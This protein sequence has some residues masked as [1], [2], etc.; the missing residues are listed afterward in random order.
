MPEPTSEPTGLPTAY[1]SPACPAGTERISVKFDP[2]GAEWA[3][4]VSSVYSGI[5]NANVP[6]TDDNILLK[7]LP[8][9][10]RRLDEEWTA[11]QICAKSGDYYFL[12]ECDCAG[13]AAWL[14][15]LNRPNYNADGSETYECTYS[16]CSDYGLN[17]FLAMTDDACD[18]SYAGIEGT[19]TRGATGPEANSLGNYGFCE[20]AWPTTDDFTMPAPA[21]TEVASITSSPTAWRGYPDRD[22]MCIVDGCYTLEFLVSGSFG[23]AC[24]DVPTD[25][26]ADNGYTCE[27]FAEDKGLTNK[28]RYHADWTSNGNCRQTCYDHGSG[29]DGDVCS[30]LWFTISSETDEL[31]VLLKEETTYFDF[32]VDG[33]S[34]NANPTAAPTG[35]ALPTPAPSVSPTTSSPSSVPSG[36]RR[37]RRCSRDLSGGRKKPS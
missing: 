27:T 35:S 18:E 13:C 15:S 4:V 20:V 22:Y 37:P 14:E 30:G 25:W 31:D 28:C 2:S 24:D 19:T 26:Q 23:S 16:S 34:F 36:V 8:D 17:A 1:P 33:T 5:F 12:A 11:G 6:K 21:S 9:T 29:Y 7:Q 32:C 10:A 3:P